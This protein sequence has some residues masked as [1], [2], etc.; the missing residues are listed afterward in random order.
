MW[1]GRR[2]GGNLPGVSIKHGQQI[3]KYRTQPCEFG[4][5]ETIH[6]CYPHQ[7][8][9]GV[10]EPLP[11]SGLRQPRLQAEENLKATRLWDRMAPLAPIP[12]RPQGIRNK[13]I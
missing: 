7:S 9:E 6:I 8:E 12:I 5:S 2:F 1:I 11:I 10:P 3:S 4:Y 13:Y